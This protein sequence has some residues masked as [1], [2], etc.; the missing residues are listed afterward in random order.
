MS[1]ENGKQ[2]KD[3]LFRTLPVVSEHMHALLALPS[4]QQKALSTCNAYA[5]SRHHPAPSLPKVHGF[6]SIFGTVEMDSFEAASAL[7]NQG[8]SKP[9]VL[10]LANEHNCGGAWCNKEGSQEEDLF[11]CSSLPLSLWPRRKVS[12]QRMPE[13][14][15]RMPRQDTIYPFTE[16]GVVYSP[17]VLVCRGRD[18]KPY[19]TENQ[20]MVAVI[21]SAAQDLREGRPHYNGPF[22]PELTREKLRSHL[23]AADYHGHTAL[24]LGAFGCGAFKNDPHELT[25]LYLELLGPGGEFE[26]CFE[27]VIFAI[28]KSSNLLERFGATFPRIDDVPGPTKERRK[29]LGEM[30]ELE[31]QMVEANQ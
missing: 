24:V 3:R 25:R 4:D 9:A 23:W 15:D 12:D 8:W 19:S 22:N 13:F 10:N 30:A 7:L 20:K 28:I 16:A 27:I 2:R 31:Q 26:G 5:Y 21:T 29:Q 18:G 14:D 1:E 17:H 11:R 6:A